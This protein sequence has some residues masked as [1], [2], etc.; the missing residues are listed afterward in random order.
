MEQL[1]NDNISFL[2]FYEIKF[3]KF[4]NMNHNTYE[5]YNKTNFYCSFHTIY[6]Q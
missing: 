2:I 5:K 6:Y 4:K 1:L 3:N